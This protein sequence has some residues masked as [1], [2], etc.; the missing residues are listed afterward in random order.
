VKRLFYI[1]LLLNSLGYSQTVIWFEGFEDYSDGDVVAA[2]N[3]SNDVGVDWTIVNTAL[4]AGTFQVQNSNSITGSN[5]FSANR[6]NGYSVNGSIWTSEVID[7]SAYSTIDIGVTVEEVGNIEPEDFVDVEYS[8]NGGAW[9]DMTNGQHNDDFGGP[10]LATD[11]IA[12]V[13]TTIQIRV[14]SYSDANGEQI[15]FDDVYVHGIVALPVE[16]ISFNTTL[17]NNEVK[18]EWETGS[19]INNDRFEVERSKD[20]INWEL[21]TTVIGAGNSNT[22]LRYNIYDIMPYLGTSYYRLK[23]IDFDGSFSYSKTEVIN[24]IKTLPVTIYPN[25][26]RGKFKLEINDMLSD[27]ILI[28][29]NDGLGREIYS[30]VIIKEYDGS[31]ILIDLMRKISTGVYYVT[32]SNSKELFNKT[33]FI[34]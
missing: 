1:L 6:A 29:V 31:I 18:L 24:N 30:K 27:D 34:Q 32:G 8:L 5:S 25:P 26:N 7:V 3:N 11:N 33:I 16:L 10:L 22:K 15:I 20:G 13:L 23:Q 19:E 9:T 2:D 12:G 21:L 28:I 17:I 14:K 4:N